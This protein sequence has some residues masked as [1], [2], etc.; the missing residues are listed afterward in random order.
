M[1]C[2]EKRA[3]NP[4]ISLYNAPRKVKSPPDILRWRNEAIIGLHNVEQR[5]S[6]IMQD[7]DNILVEWEDRTSKNPHTQD[8]EDV[9]MVNYSLRRWRRK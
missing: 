3:Y 4:K 1:D 7:I 5:L 9:S 6:G 8:P 2:W